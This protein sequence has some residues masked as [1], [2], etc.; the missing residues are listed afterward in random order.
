MVGDDRERWPV[1]G[2]AREDNSTA[3]VVAAVHPLQALI[4]T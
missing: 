2:E 4:G 3:P 1:G